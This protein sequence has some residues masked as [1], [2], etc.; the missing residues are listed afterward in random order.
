MWS[1]QTLTYNAGGGLNWHKAFGKLYL[2]WMNICTTYDLSLSLYITVCVY[3][4][5]EMDRYA[6]GS[7]SHSRL[8]LEIAQVPIKS[9]HHFLAFLAK[10][11]CEEYL[12]T[13]KLWFVCLFVCLFIFR[14]G[15][16]EGE[17]HWRVR[18]TSI[19][20]LLHAPNWDLVHNPGTC[21]DG[22]SLFSSQARARSAE[23]HQPGQIVVVLRMESM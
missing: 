12:N 16:R 2:L 19:G 3:S 4:P 5:E 11:K 10:I 15:G 7:A 18:E 6:H 8:K 14:E 20:C 1:N 23:P 13:C 22:I 9:T 21:P 17:K